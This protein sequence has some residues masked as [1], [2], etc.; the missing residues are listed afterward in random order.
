VSLLAALLFA[1]TMSTYS[2]RV[3]AQ[4]DFVFVE[5]K[6]SRPIARSDLVSALEVGAMVYSISNNRR[7]EVQT[8][9]EHEPNG[10]AIVRFVFFTYFSNPPAV[11]K[12]WQTTD[13]NLYL[14][15]EQT[16]RIVIQGEKPGTDP[17]GAEGLNAHVQ[18][19]FD[20]YIGYVSKEVLQAEAVR[21][22]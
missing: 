6:L 13:L 15:E 21:V 14:K 18:G 22:G 17:P 19:S 10:T 16:D 8:S 4:Q 7:D 5:Y 20:A 3:E 2:I 11:P 12:R 9:V 1:F